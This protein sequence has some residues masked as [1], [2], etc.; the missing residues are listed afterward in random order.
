MEAAPCLKCQYYFIPDLDK[1]NLF[2]FAQLY[3][4]HSSPLLYIFVALVQSR[5]VLWMDQLTQSVVESS[6][7]CNSLSV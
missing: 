7:G 3:E 2:L 6:Q 1:K 4:L 5:D